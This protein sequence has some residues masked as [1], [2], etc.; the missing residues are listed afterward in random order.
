MFDTIIEKKS[1]FMSRIGINSF[2][3][4]SNRIINITR[5]IAARNQSLFEEKA[6]R[7]IFRKNGLLSKLQ[8]INYFLICIKVNIENTNHV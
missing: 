7:I 5:I 1:Y 3:K 2:T 8:L 6:F 4:K